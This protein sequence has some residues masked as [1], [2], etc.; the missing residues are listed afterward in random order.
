[1]PELLTILKVGIFAYV[2]TILISPEMI[3]HFYYKWIDKLPDLLF[4]PLGG[5]AICFA[6]QC[7]LWFYLFTHL[8]GYNFFDHIFFI[9]GVILTVM[10][11]DKIIDYE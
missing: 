9:C 5:C 2:F 6:G 10:L 4:K 11:I 8:H 7:G 1:M 3:L